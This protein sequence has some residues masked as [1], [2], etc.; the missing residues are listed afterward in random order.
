[1]N[2]EIYNSREIQE[3]LHSQHLSQLFQHLQ[4]QPTRLLSLQRSI[5]HLFRSRVARQR[6]L[7]KLASER[8]VKQTI[9]LLLLCWRKLQKYVSAQR[10]EKRNVD[11][12]RKSRT[13]LW[14]RSWKAALSKSQRIQN[15]QTL[16]QERHLRSALRIW[17]RF[18]T[19][20]EGCRKLE[21]MRSVDL[22][23]FKLRWIFRSWKTHTERE[24]SSYNFL[25]GGEKML[26]ILASGKRVLP[27]LTVAL[28]CRE[29]TEQ[30]NSSLARLQ[31][32]RSLFNSWRR[33]ILVIRRVLTDHEAVLLSIQRHRTLRRT[34]REWRSISLS[35]VFE[36]NKTID[37]SWQRWMRFA[38]VRIVSR[39]MKRRGADVFQLRK[40]FQAVSCWLS[41]KD[42]RGRLR[43]SL[44][45][46]HEY[47]KLKSTMRA[48]VGWKFAYALLCEERHKT[49][50][51]MNL[52]LTNLRRRSWSRW[53]QWHQSER[54]A[55]ERKREWVQSEINLS[56]LQVREE[57]LS[58]RVSKREPLI[59]N[60]REVFI[61]EE[62]CSE[63]EE[64]R[65]DLMLRGSPSPHPLVTQRRYF[66]AFSR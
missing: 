28:R 42:R 37:R 43:D 12:I 47:L 59:R 65:D 50:C 52:Y 45:R 57:A 36:K 53:I 31:F 55:K 34:W 5:F 14:F 62:S 1:M 21:S 9:H 16:Y 22:S 33:V 17:R 25:E 35:L 8:G 51:A 63:S 56:A 27:P 23:R 40:L 6:R 64:D 3:S 58:R 11:W 61:C 60:H 32:Q 15:H 66:H 29:V 18:L 30:R 20:G 54:A 2:E 39:Q 19:H 38:S 48:L 46:C 44:S 41:F 26:A 13:S 10:R 49:G 4:E 24:L 7:K